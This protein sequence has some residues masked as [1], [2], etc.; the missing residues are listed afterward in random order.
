MLDREVEAIHRLATVVISHEEALIRASDL[1]GDFDALLALAM[2]AK[3]Y[4]W[5]EPQMTTDNVLHVEGGR[6]P[7][8]E[9]VVP[10][11][12][13]NDCELLGGQFSTDQT[14]WPRQQ[15]IILTGPNHSGKSVYLKQIAII[16][17]LAHIG[18]YVPATRAKIGLTDKILT[19]ISTRE[20]VARTE[21]AFSIDLKQVS[22][23][24]VCC[25]PRSLVIIDEFGKGTNVDDGAGLL[26]ALLN[27]FFSLGHNMPR[28]LTATHFHEV[29]TNDFV[30]LYDG[31]ALH[32]MDVS[33]DWKASRTEDQITHLFKL[34]PGLCASSYG[35][36][37]AALNG[38]PST[39]VERAEAVASLLSRHEDINLA[40][41]KLSADEQKQ[42]EMAEAVARRFVQGDVSFANQN[43]C[44]GGE[45]SS[46]ASK[47]LDQI[48]SM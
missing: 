32:H 41:A 15:S 44:S 16:V 24:M 20:S 42:L 22:R 33:T 19:R 14:T 7:L 18:S 30:N 28:L 3:K 12:V 43:A 34:V 27:H 36:R 39:V 31:V 48:L 9:L 38:V 47:L 37:C 2:G 13:P 45:R 21:S 23:A 40:C 5:V 35:G 1:C 17:Y 25:T 6:H 11:F 29:L 10:T 4:Q 26:A 46:D 8:Q